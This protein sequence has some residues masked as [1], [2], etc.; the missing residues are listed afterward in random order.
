[1]Y[2]LDKDDEVELLPSEDPEEYKIAPGDWLTMMVFTNNGYKLVDAGLAGGGGIGQIMQQSNQIRFLVEQSGIARFPLIDTVEVQGLSVLEA[3]RK[4]ES[5]YE[6]HLV[7]PWVQITVANRR[8]FVFA[9]DEQGMVV[10]LPNEHMSLMEVLASAGGIPSTS[11]AYKIKIVRK[12]SG[13]D[14]SKIYRINLRNSEEA[15]SGNIIVKANDVIIV[16]PTFETTFLAQLTPFFAFVTST[17]AIYA[18]F[19]SSN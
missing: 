12:V 17:V 16:D 15:I 1:M 8:V 11:K 5:R 14:K 19:R 9:G 18:L 10:P 7:D 3:A 4:L 6:L 2:R 13:S